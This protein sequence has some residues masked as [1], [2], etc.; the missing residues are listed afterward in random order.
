MSMRIRLNEKVISL[1]MLLL[2]PIAFFHDTL[3][4]RTTKIQWD[5]LDIHY[6]ALLYQSRMIRKGLLPLWDPHL[7]CGYSYVGHVQAAVYH[8]LH[9]LMSLLGEITPVRTQWLVMSNVLIGLFCTFILLRTLRIRYPFCALG[10]ILY[11]FS[12]QFLGHTTHLGILEGISIL[13][14]AIAGIV[15]GFRS[16][17]LMWFL[18]SGI[19]LGIIAHAGHF[20]TTIYAAFILT[21]HILVDP[22]REEERDRQKAR[23]RS[24]IA[25]LLIVFL[26]AGGLS[27]IILV[28]TMESAIESVRNSLSYSLASSESFRM[29]SLK[30]LL[31]PDWYGG[32]RSPYTGPWD[33]TNQQLYISIAGAM[34]LLASMSG[35]R[36]PR[37]R[38]CWM[39][40]FGGGLFA[41]GNATPIH[42]WALRII[43][44]FDLVRTPA[45]FLPI[46]WL[47]AAI[48]VALTAQRVSPEK[49]R[50]SDGRFFLFAALAVASSAILI[51]ARGNSPAMPRLL[52]PGALIAL[53]VIAMPLLRIASGR[54]RTAIWAWGLCALTL[55]DLFVTY[56]DT[57]LVFGKGDPYED[58]RETDL[59]R[60]IADAYATGDLFRVHEWVSR[61]VILNNEGSIRNWYTTLGR[62]SGI[63]LN[64]LGMLIR[65][66]EYNPQILDLLRVRF[67]L[68]SS[69]KEAPRVVSTAGVDGMITDDPFRDLVRRSDT[70]YENMNPFPV[71][72][73]VRNWKVAQSVE[74]VRELIPATD[75]TTTA[76]LE[77][78]PG[79][80]SDHSNGGEI[81]IRGYGE[82]AVSFVS[83]S[84]TESLVIM[85]DT[86]HSGWRA[87]M[88]GQPVP[89]LTANLAL[90]AIPVPAGSHAIDLT[91]SPQSYR[92]GAFVTLLTCSIVAAALIRFLRQFP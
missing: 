18:L 34:L 71:A 73:H 39:V 55:T 51:A 1:S 84:D 79:L 11:V 5:V 49:D 67:V 15:L 16:G 32:I 28:P 47:H 35:L 12:G 7:F 53:T 23:W 46:V 37:I 58:L 63:H 3:F 91:F 50:L 38:F 21:V 30:T 78:D 92:L 4:G 69:R 75:L 65:Q 76:I 54:Y 20:Q 56:R 90:R 83:R 17:I 89:V 8:P 41:L 36:N 85:T 29:E 10:A 81:E 62:I 88:D 45:A 42:G 61:T 40:V 33:R 27:G 68:K 44:G 26:A 86:I 2:T 72:F 25:A 80:R 9:I 57:D 52:M 64:R 59:H 43:P 24:T 31:F 14:L 74:A 87:R 22:M 13:P 70:L 48:L 66:A 77:T 6:P 60:T 19:L 82:H